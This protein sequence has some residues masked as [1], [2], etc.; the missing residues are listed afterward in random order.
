MHG[1]SHNVELDL[2]DGMRFRV[3]TGS[4]HAIE[5]DASAEVGGADTGARPMEL[6]LA[7]L[8]GCEAMDTI[9]I[10]RKMRQDV[11]S[12]RVAAHGVTAPEHPKKYTSIAIIHRLGGRAIAEANVRRAL[13]LSMA[14]YCPVFATI[15]PAVPVSVSYEILDEGGAPV[16]K[17]EVRLD[18]AEPPA[19]PRPGR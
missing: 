8:A 1:M 13:L 3:Q 18:D 12:Y 17:G 14:R 6:L 4:G 19:D 11:T 2:L 5:I 7:A 15:A 10:L 16:V 9:S